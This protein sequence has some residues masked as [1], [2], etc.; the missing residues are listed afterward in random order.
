MARIP[1]APTIVMAGAGKGSG[2]AT[3]GIL[4]LFIAVVGLVAFFTGNLERWIDEIAGPRGD[5]GADGTAY[6]PG[7]VIRFPSGTEVVHNPDGSR[8][9][10]G[11]WGGAAPAPGA[12][13]PQRVPS[14]GGGARRI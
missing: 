6:P 1:T 3:A 13:P 14:T 11:S 2:S 10:S 4:L 7:T 5:S 8:T 12:R 9:G